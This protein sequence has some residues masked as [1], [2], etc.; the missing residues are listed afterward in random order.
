MDVYGSV[1]P[2]VDSEVSRGLGDL[3]RPKRG[4][5]AVSAAGSEV[6]DLRNPHHFNDVSGGGEGSRTPGLF[7]ATE[8]LCQLSYTPAG[9]PSLLGC[10]PRC[11]DVW[12]SA[13]LSAT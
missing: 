13:I 12:R 1:L 3:L 9:P 7:D 8:A 10:T 6:G 2:E 11:A 5:I 4:Q